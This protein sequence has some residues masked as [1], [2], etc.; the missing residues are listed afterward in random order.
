[1]QKNTEEKYEFLDLHE[2]LYRSFSLVSKNAPLLLTT[3]TFN[4]SSIPKD[5]DEISRRLFLIDDLMM[6]KASSD[7]KIPFMPG[8]TLSKSDIH[9]CFAGLS[10]H[11]NTTPNI[12]DKTKGKNDSELGI[13]TLKKAMD[14]LNDPSL[15][16]HQRI[17]RQEHVNELND[18][19]TPKAIENGTVVEEYSRFATDED[20][21]IIVSNFQEILDI[22]SPN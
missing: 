9:E 16:S 4:N 21:D 18:Q 13:S 7:N 8:S 14:I 10:W 2:K 6:K 22:I 3:S 1:M 12:F 19:E 20:L 15:R 5:I 11:K 17:L